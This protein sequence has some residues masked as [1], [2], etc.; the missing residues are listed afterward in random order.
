MDAIKYFKEAIDYITE[1]NN[2]LNIFIGNKIDQ[3]DYEC[4]KFFAKHYQN[5]LVI[6]SID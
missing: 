1:D 6:L 2:E 4:V 3:E 5:W